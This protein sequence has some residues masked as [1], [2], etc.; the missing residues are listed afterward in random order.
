[1]TSYYPHHYP[2]SPAP[3][4]GYPYQPGAA[5]F[6]DHRQEPPPAPA[7]RRRAEEARSELDAWQRYDVDWQLFHRAWLL[8]VRHGEQAWRRR[9]TR[10]LAPYG[11]GFLFIQPATGDTS[12]NALV[13]AATRLW[14]AG[15]EAEDPTRLLAKLTSQARGCD[16]DARW[17]LRQEI[18]NR[19]DDTMQQAAVYTGLALSNLNTRTGSFHDVCATATSEMDI[20]G[21]ILYVSAHPDSGHGVAGRADHSGEV[22]MFVAE[23]RGASEH[24]LLTIHS[25]GALSTHMMSSPYPYAETDL[26]YLYHDPVHGRLLQAMLHLDAAVRDADQARRDAD[27]RDA[28]QPRD[29]AIGRGNSRRRQS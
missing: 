22:R 17:D 5:P 21:T 11:L 14:L 4:L 8:N 26:G 25:H 2:Q 23:R 9:Y 27:L 12:R 1:V 16:P 19:Y 6:A 15:P 7:E 13:T 3:P 29:G 28:D 10:P 18:A 20:P 24:N